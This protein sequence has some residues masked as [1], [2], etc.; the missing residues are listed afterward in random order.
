MINFDD[1]D[2]CG[3]YWIKEEII[4]NEKKAEAW[5]GIC[6]KTRKVAFMRHVTSQLDALIPLIMQDIY[7]CENVSCDDGK[8]CLNI[9][10]PYATHNKIIDGFWAQENIG[11][12]DDLEEK[13]IEKWLKK[14]IKYIEEEFVEKQ[15]EK[16]YE[17]LFKSGF[18]VSHINESGFNTT[19]R[20]GE[21]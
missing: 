15:N 5:W 1:I 20:G 6:K 19:V 16:E 13:D 7:Y 9:D 21:L 10:C 3:I 18:G 14:T 8:Y 2:S 12:F 17:K 11:L 4:D